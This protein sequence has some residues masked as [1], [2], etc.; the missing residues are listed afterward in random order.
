MR[1]SARFGLFEGLE[2]DGDPIRD[3]RLFSHEPLLDLV[4]LHTTVSR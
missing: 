4:G 3:R 2:L 1:S